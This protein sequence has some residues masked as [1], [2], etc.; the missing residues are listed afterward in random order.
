MSL[1]FSKSTGSVS[2]VAFSAAM[3]L[4]RIFAGLIGRPRHPERLARLFPAT[5]GASP[6]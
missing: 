1:G 6:C 2:L 3:A 5:S 4:G